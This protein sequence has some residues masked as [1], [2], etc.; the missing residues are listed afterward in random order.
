V[1]STTCA[2]HSRV[3]ALAMKPTSVALCTASGAGS[4]A[5]PAMNGGAAV[6]GDRKAVDDAALADDA[7][8]GHT[9]VNVVK[10]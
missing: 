3:S 2:S 1:L 9:L 10:R 6:G 5:K 7:Y 4:T 8:T